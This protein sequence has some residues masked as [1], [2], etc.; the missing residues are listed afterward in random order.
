MNPTH[1]EILAR[2]DALYA[3]RE[4]PDAVRSSIKL[5]QTAT[6]VDDFEAAWRLG[7]AFFFLGQETAVTTEEARA[8]YVQGIAASKRAARF[9]PERVE[10]CFWLGV[11]LALLAQLEAEDTTT[12][13]NK[14]SFIA[15]TLNSFNA[16][17]HALRARRLLR[18]AVRLDP[19]YHGTG[20]L[21]VLA[22]LEHKLPRYLG[23]GARR[24]RAH[25]AQALESAPQNPVT[26]LYF[27]EMLL[28]LGDKEGARLELETLLRLT[29]DDPS[30][31][32]EIR[33][34]QKRAHM[35]LNQPLIE[36]NTPPPLYGRKQKQ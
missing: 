19:V 26:R 8:F 34:D 18:R 32:F 17:R 28:D 22:R 7:R 29:D 11:N 27:A 5:L 2:A 30:W 36:T 20:P 14:I 35:L 21:R 15:H 23:G 31:S 3:A 6:L 12:A 16:L 13:R 33:R 10:G 25:F 9:V 24:A 4:Q 1:T